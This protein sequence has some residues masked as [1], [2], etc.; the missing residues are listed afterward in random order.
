METY[1]KFK[2]ENKESILTLFV[3]EGRDKIT[4]FLQYFCRFLSWY[5]SQTDPQR[6]ARYYKM[7]SKLLSCNKFQTVLKMQGVSTG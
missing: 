4:K 2:D 3:I 1:G 6:S 5:F 7:S